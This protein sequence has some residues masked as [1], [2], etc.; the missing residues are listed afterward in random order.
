MAITKRVRVSF[1][2]KIVQAGIDS[3]SMAKLLAEEV[4]RLGKTS[5]KPD[6][7][8]RA[9]IV[10]SLTNGPEAAFELALK[11]ALGD[12]IK[13]EFN[14]VSGRSSQKVSNVSIRVIK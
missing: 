9:L 10:E 7:L 1:D 13:E 6:G 5:E 3:E 2:L 12:I 11:K 4:K 8:Q 14:D